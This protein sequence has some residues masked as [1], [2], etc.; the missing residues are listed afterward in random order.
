[1][2]KVYSSIGKQGLLLAALMFVWV[3]GSSF[4]PKARQ[5]AI[6]MARHSA[7]DGSRAIL[8]M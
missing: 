1:M 8:S 4:W 2:K 3:L 5:L 7:K 6:R